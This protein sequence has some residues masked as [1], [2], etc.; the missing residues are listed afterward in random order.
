MLAT[1]EALS[2]YESNTTAPPS[3]Q[4]GPGPA[5]LLWTVPGA[6]LLFVMGKPAPAISRVAPATRIG[7]K[8]DTIRS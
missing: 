6:E 2:G 4:H 5:I 7:E 8:P 3:V 1:V